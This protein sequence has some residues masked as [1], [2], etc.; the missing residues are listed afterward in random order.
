MKR[1]AGFNAVRII[2]RTRKKLHLWILNLVDSK[3]GGAV[4][5]NEQQYPHHIS[6]RFIKEPEKNEERRKLNEA[7][8]RWNEMAADWLGTP[9]SIFGCAWHF[10]KFQ[11]EK[12][13]KTAFLFIVVINT[14]KKNNLLNQPKTKSNNETKSQANRNE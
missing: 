4:N 3:K 7:W 6:K 14:M 8:K 1:A 2:Q 12:M 5:T 9:S 10:H 13:K 11:H